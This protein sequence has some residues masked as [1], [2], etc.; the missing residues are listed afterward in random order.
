[1]P[2][3]EREAQ[4]LGVEVDRTV[5]IG[6]LIANADDLVSQDRLGPLFPADGG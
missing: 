5:Q 6:H 3:G 1:L 2:L 4:P